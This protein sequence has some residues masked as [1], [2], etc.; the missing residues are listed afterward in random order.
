MEEKKKK[1]R[2][3]KKFPA[4]RNAVQSRLGKKNERRSA[5]EG[6]IWIETGKKITTRKR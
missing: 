6:F 1:K 4:A 5:S 3:S 2:T